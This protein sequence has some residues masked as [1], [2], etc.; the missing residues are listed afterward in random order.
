VQNT[1]SRPS[2]WSSIGVMLTAKLIVALLFL[3]LALV[4][5]QRVVYEVVRYNDSRVNLFSGR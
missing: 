1:P 5:S 4:K 2:S 3:Y